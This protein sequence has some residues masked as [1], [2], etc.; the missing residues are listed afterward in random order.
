MGGQAP[1]KKNC[2]IKF[3]ESKGCTTAKGS[4]HIKYKCP[5]CHR[6]IMFRNEKEIIMAHIRTNLNDMDISVK[7]FLEWKERNC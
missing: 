7:D 4:K 3:L 6:S 1:V 2:W 5:G